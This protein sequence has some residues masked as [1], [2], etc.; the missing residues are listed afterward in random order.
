MSMEPVTLTST[1]LAPLMEVSSRGLEMAIRAASSALFLPAARPTPMW[2][3][4]AS[5]MTADTSAKSRLMNPVFLIRSEM[6]WT[7]C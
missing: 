7:A 2:A 6:D 1:P 5:F 4:P 3:R